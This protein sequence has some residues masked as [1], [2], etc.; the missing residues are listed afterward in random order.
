M[1][2]ASRTISWWRPLVAAALGC[3]LAVACD[4]TEEPT[5]TGSDLRVEELD[6]R[7]EYLVRCNLMPDQDTCMAAETFDPGLVQAVGA[8]SFGRVGYDPELAADWL[9]TLRDISCDDT[10]ENRRLL[11]EARAKV[12]GG[13]IDLGDACFADEECQGE[14]ICDRSACP[15]N[16]LCCTGECVEFRTLSVG[17]T[18]PLSQQGMRLTA[19]CEE[20]AYCQ[21]PPFDGMGDPPTQGQCV[22]RSDNGLPCDQVDGCLDGQRCAVGGSGNCYKLSESGEMCNPMLQQGSCLAISEVCSP[23]SST[24]EAAPGPGQPC[25]NGRCAGW[26]R[27][28]DPDGSGGMCVAMPRAG[29]ACDGSIPCLGD[30]F[31][32]NDAGVCALSATLLV[33]V[34]GEPPPPPDPMM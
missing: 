32:D 24:C 22:A 34:E 10:L 27:C 18:C 6:A 29:E 9:Q 2:S 26:A 7:C 17:E 11:S 8:T 3:V 30:L 5:V 25:V 4:Q 21:S 15:G 19:G 14:A 13:R 31:C 28:M 16:Q 12:F 33:C 20:L 23:G 1:D